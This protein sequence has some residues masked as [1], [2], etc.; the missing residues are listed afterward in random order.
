L[1]EHRWFDLRDAV[2]SRKVPPLYR[3]FVAAAF[4]HEQDADK[5]LKA[6]ARSGASREQLAGM[7]HA[8]YRLYS[9]VGRYRKAILELRQ[10]WALGPDRASTDPAVTADAAA[11]EVLPDLKLVSRQPATVTYTN[12]LDSPRVVSPMT[13]NGQAV[14]FAIDTDGG[15]ARLQGDEKFN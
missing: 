5:E 2:T 1:D 11:M 4:N 10:C 15:S 14:R 6:A 8:M 9:R 12:W 13:V 7:H 3:F